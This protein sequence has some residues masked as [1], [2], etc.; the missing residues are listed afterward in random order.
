MCILKLEFE[1]NFDPST[2][3]QFFF[4]KK[5]KNVYD[6]C[7]IKIMDRKISQKTRLTNEKKFNC[8]EII[9]F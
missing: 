7:L 8:R 4:L 2:V 9:H 3:L 1:E 6:L 5:K